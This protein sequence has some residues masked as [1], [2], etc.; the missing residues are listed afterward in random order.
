MKSSRS[1]KDVIAGGRYS[2]EPP[3][4]DFS[5]WERGNYLFISEKERKRRQRARLFDERL[6]Q[7]KQIPRAEAVYADSEPHESSKKNTTE[8]ISHREDMRR[9]SCQQHSH[10]RENRENSGSVGDDLVRRHRPQEMTLMNSRSPIRHD[11]SQSSSRSRH[12]SYH[13]L[14]SSKEK[15]NI[16]T[17]KDD[18]VRQEYSPSSSQS[19]GDSLTLGLEKKIESDESDCDMSLEMKKLFVDRSENYLASLSARTHFEPMDLLFNEFPEEEETDPPILPS[20]TF[21]ISPVYTP[22]SS[23]ESLASKTVNSPRSRFFFITSI[24]VNENLIYM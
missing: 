14:T 15:I 19:Q 7:V 1:Y 12:D 20:R 21:C 24:V 9:D 8:R 5:V 23:T 16:I 2:K 11:K 18:N 10:R 3:G 6:R 4:K 17:D 22:T 13:H